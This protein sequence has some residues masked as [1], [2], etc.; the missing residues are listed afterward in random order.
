M[1][2]TTF[3]YVCHF[4]K[5]FS[6]KNYFKCI[7]LGSEIQIYCLLP[8]QECE[9]PDGFQNPENVECDC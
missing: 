3:M 6:L 8:K 5:L 1:N 7:F 9:F 2:Y 4:V